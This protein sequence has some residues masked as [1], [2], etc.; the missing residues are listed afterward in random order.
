MNP[1]RGSP[2][3]DPKEDAQ[4]SAAGGQHVR[5]ASLLNEGD[6]RGDSGNESVSDVAAQGVG[7]AN[8][9]S[10]PDDDSMRVVLIVGIAFI[11]SCGVG[12][13]RR[14]KKQSQN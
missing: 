7:N 1:V 12:A 8:D 9:S 10:K 11:V 4:A 14:R 2:A 13:V 6:S 5:V 3:Q